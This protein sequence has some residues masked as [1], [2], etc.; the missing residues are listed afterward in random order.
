MRDK[1]GRFVRLNRSIDKCMH[2]K[3]MV[4][5]RGMAA[6]PLLSP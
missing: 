2:G 1:S 3:E 4:G 6:F 5:V